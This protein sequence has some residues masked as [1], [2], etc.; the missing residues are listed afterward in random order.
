MAKVRINQENEIK[1]EINMLFYFLFGKYITHFIN[2]DLS[3]YSSTLKETLKNNYPGIETPR[4]NH[5]VC[6]FEIRVESEIFEFL[7]HNK[8]RNVLNKSGE[9]SVFS[10]NLTSFRS[11][12]Y[13]LYH[14]FYRKSKSFPDYI[15]FATDADVLHFGASDLYYHNL[16][17]ISPIREFFIHHS[18]FK[19][20][21]T[22]F[23]H[24]ACI[25][26][27]KYLN[28]ENRL[29]KTVFFKLE[30]EINKN[31]SIFYEHY[32]EQVFKNFVEGLLKLAK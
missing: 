4:R 26:K 23:V 25:K 13:S 6:M 1:K 9:I 18:L 12:M 28:N 2:V 20:K 27:Y 7:Y 11:A 16:S 15:D 24:K 14:V 21:Y 17:L 19:T 5:I 31:M 30:D 32:I 10:I 29:S 22:T 8:T 3:H